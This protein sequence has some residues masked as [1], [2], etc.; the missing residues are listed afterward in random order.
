MSNTTAVS[1]ADFDREVLEAEDPVLVDFWAPWCMPC[2]ML[3]PTLDEL[4][5]DYT[6]KAK[7]VKV[8][9][10]ENQELAV[11]YGIR[12]IPTLILFKDGEAID[13]AVG[14]QPKKELAERLD[15]AIVSNY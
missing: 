8:N 11:K 14:V 4:A 5:G 1:T 3:A 9:T 12:G 7:V 10:D 2:R 15:R 6:G 13:R